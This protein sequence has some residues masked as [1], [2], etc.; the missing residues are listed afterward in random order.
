MVKVFD[1][2]EVRI[3]VPDLEHTL[4]LHGANQGSCGVRC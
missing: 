1:K 4:I 2:G 3:R